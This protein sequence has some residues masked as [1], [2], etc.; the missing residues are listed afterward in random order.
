MYGQARVRY[1]GGYPTCFHAPPHQLRARTRSRTIP[2]PAGAP[3][4]LQPL[5][6]LGF[7][8]PSGLAQQPRSFKY[9]PIWIRSGDVATTDGGGA[10]RARVSERSA[11]HPPVASAKVSGLGLRLRAR[12]ATASP[13]R[14]IIH[15]F[16]KFPCLGAVCGKTG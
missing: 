4:N 13:R 2:T 11:G 12:L 9:R 7:F 5:A 10:A 3:P 6:G 14:M 8:E 1:R 15:G 16:A